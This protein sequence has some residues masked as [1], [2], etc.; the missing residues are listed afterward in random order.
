[1]TSE[2]LRKH[3]RIMALRCHPDKNT[4]PDANAQF[5][6]VYEA[7]EFLSDNKGQ[8]ESQTYLDI[9]RDFMNSQ[10]P[11]VNIIVNKLSA[12][13]G[14]KIATYLDAIDREI[15]VDIYNLL[16]VNREHL[17]I[18]DTIL[19]EIKRLVTKR[20]RG[21]ERIVLNPSIDDLLNDNLYKLVLGDRTF[22]IP[23]W[24][25][26]VVYDISG[27]N[28]YV[29]CQPK[30]PADVRID[31]HNTLTVRLERNIS[32]VL[33]GGQLTFRIGNKE[34]SVSSNV[35][36]IVNKQMHRIVRAGVLGIDI[37]NVYNQDNRGDILLDITLLER[38]ERKERTEP[39]VPCNPPFCR[40]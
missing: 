7:Y 26:E 12:V 24:H 25:R 4:A 2:L 40:A 19:E 10:S 8:Q 27:S 31:E 21:D 5:Q 33:A 3:Y 23:L 17:R 39:T 9:L 36:K 37:N 32:D 34:Y 28:L 30:L 38:K 1:M 14:E 18:P 35:L 22:L 29:E 6:R 20:T 15:V 13:C 11:M 16:I